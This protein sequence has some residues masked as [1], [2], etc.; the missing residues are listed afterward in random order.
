M[1]SFIIISLLIW[2]Q[3]YEYINFSLCEYRSSG[4]T[5]RASCDEIEV[6]SPTSMGNLTP[7]K[8]TS[9]EKVHISCASL[10]I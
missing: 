10:D 7:T 2:K 5:L 8:N 1:Y 4:D 6:D 9:T 3:R